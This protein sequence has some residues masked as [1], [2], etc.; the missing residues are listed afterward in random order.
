M[1]K[2]QVQLTKEMIQAFVMHPDWPL[3][4]E[5]IEGHFANSTDIQEIDVKNDST[6]V[7]AEVIATQKIDKDLQSLKDAFLTLRKN[8]GKVRQNYE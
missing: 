7:H 2:Q 8:Y 3:M 6:V 5:Y 4:L 1:A